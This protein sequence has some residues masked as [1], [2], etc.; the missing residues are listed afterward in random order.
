MATSALRVNHVDADGRRY[1][2]SDLRNPGVRPNLTYEYKG[3]QPHPNGWAVSREKM[4]EYDRQGRLWFPPDKAGRIRLKR[5]LDESPGQHIQNLWEDIP[6]ISSQARERLGYPT[7]KP[8]A[9]LD[10]IITA[11]SNEGDVVVA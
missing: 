8:E 10:R 7:Q 9:L 2:L 5:Y 1:T 11:S 6:P 4:E 3:Y